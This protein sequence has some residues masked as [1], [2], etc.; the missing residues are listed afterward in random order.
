MPEND[1]E[2][3]QKCNCYIDSIL[4]LMIQAA[5]GFQGQFSFGIDQVKLTHTKNVCCLKRQPEDEYELTFKDGSMTIYSRL[6]HRCYNCEG[7]ES[8]N[9][10]SSKKVCKV[11]F[12]DDQVQDGSK[13]IPPLIMGEVLKIWNE[14]HE[15]GKKYIQTMVEG[16]LRGWIG[17]AKG[18]LDSGGKGKCSALTKGLKRY[19]IKPNRYQCKEEVIKDFCGRELPVGGGHHQ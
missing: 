11:T 17:Y 14:L 4:T 19:F 1:F 8:G 2:V 9:C 16:D 5:K 6:W 18:D 15:G 10:D 7:K 12:Q 3:E 13:E